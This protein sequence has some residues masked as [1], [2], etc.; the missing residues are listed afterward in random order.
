M[1]FLQEVGQDVGEHEGAPGLEEDIVG[2]VQK[3]QLHPRELV[4]LD[5]LFELRLKRTTNL[6]QL[7]KIWLRLG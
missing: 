2:I 1:V 6:F 7:G 3:I 4:L 5:Q